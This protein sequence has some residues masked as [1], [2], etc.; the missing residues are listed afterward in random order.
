MKGIRRRD[1]ILYFTYAGQ[2]RNKSY[3]TLAKAKEA[4]KIIEGAILDGRL[5]LAELVKPRQEKKANH[6]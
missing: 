2:R 6:R 4:Q 1:K 3:P 5:T